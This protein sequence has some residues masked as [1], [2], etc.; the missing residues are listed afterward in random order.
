MAGSYGR[1]LIRFSF[2]CR[3]PMLPSDP[4]SAAASNERLELPG[5]ASPTRLSVTCCINQNPQLPDCWPT[6]V[7][8]EDPSSEV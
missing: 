1:G 2:P 8:L 4:R 7:R 6:W 3:G 5:S